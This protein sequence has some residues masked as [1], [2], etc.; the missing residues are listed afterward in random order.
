MDLPRFVVEFIDDKK[1]IEIEAR[2]VVV[3][4][5]YRLAPEHPF[6]AAVEDAIDAVRWVSSDPPELGTIDKSRVAVGGTSAGGNLAIT[7][8]ISALSLDVPLPSA[9]PSLANTIMHP[10]VS[11]L[12]IVPVVDNT[13]T[14]DG[15]WSP[16]AETAPWLTPKRMEWYRK[17]YFSRQEDPSLW[18]ASPNLAPE[19]LLKRLPKTWIAVSEQDLLAP[20]A[21]AFGEQLKSLGVEAETVIVEGGTHS[22]LSLNGKIARGKKMIEE[23]AHHLKGVFGT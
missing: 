5:N 3:T 8:T 1:L 14:A 2:C 4:V 10:P 6:P 7:A 15:V 23:A 11:L 20:E 18:D 16:N 12:L 13:A 19:S 17:L 22:I 21:V 9:R